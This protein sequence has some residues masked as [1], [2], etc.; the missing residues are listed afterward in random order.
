MVELNVIL[1]RDE[2]KRRNIR[3]RSFS[4]ATNAIYAIFLEDFFDAFEYISRII[5]ALSTVLQ[6]HGANA[7]WEK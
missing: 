5:R 6:R 4:L 1:I 7:H 2:T 3:L